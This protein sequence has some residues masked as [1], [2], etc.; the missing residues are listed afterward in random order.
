M[1]KTIEEPHVWTRR[2]YLAGECDHHTYYLGVARVIGFS[3]IAYWVHTITDA[4]GFRAA[5]AVDPNL[6]TITLARWDR[7][8]APIRQLVA[9]RNR[10]HGIMAVTWSG[11][12]LA[13][14]T[15]CWSLSDSVCVAK[16]VARE[17]AEG[18][19]GG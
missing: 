3:A 6:N 19:E 1:V 18:R 14:G 7:L 15:F 4:E 11:A 13:P 16:A 2:E 12:P 5:I 8:D 17:I 10:S 9:E